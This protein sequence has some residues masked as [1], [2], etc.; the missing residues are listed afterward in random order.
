MDKNIWIDLDIFP[1]MS[2]GFRLTRTVDNKKSWTV[3]DVGLRVGGETSQYNAYYFVN[4]DKLVLNV[5][6]V[7]LFLNPAQGLLYDVWYM[8][9]KYNYPIPSTGLTS[10]YPQPGGVDWTF[11]NPQPT[12][13]TFFEF[14]QTFWLNMINVRNR[15]ISSDGK[16]GGYP[17]LDSIYWKYLTSNQDVNIPNDNYTYKTMID[18]VTGMGDYWIRLVEQMIPATTLWLSR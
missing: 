9:N 15:Q 10:P 14:A 16:T 3:T 11:I 5:K 12:K 17:T 7:D 4:N 18:Y 8:S 13:K 6:N 2:E 1:Y